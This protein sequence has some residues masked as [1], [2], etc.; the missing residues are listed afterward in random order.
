MKYCFVIF[1]VVVVSEFDNIK[2]L[3]LLS[4][5]FC[6]VVNFVLMVLL[7]VADHIIFIFGQ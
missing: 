4:P 1:S 7:V 2:L 5:W 3:L 6:L